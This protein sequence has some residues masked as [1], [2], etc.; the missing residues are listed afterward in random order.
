MKKAFLVLLTALLAFSFFSCGEKKAE[1]AEVEKPAVTVKNPDTFVYGTIGTVS[2]LDPAV[3]YDNAS[4]VNIN[5]MY[6]QLITYN[7]GELDL[8]PVL[9]EEVPT[10]ANGGISADGKTYRFKIKKGIKFHDGS[11]LT[12]EDVEYSIERTMVVDVDH[13]PQWMYFMVFLND[14]G[15][16]NDDGT[17]KYTYDDI[18]PTVEVDG[19][20]VVFNLY[21]PFEPFLGIIAGYW[22]AI[23]NKDFVAANGGW[24]G[25]GADMARVNNP[26]TGEETLYEVS[27]G[28]GPY[29]LDR[30][31]KGDELVITRFDDYHGKKPALAKGIY[32]VLDEWSTRKLMFLQGDIDYAYVEPNF[33]ADMDAEEG[34]TSAKDLPRLSLSGIMFNQDTNDVDNPL[35]GSGAVDGNGVPGDFFANLDARLA[36]TYAWDEETFIRDVNSGYAVDPVTPFPFGLAYKNENQERLPFDLAKSEEYFKK[37]Y[38]GKLWEN[39]FVMDLAYNEG[40]EIRG[41]GLRILAENVNSLNPKFKVTVRSVVWAEYLDLNKNKRMPLFFIGWAPDYPDPDNYA[42]PFMYSKGYFPAKGGYSNPEAD[43]LILKAKYSTDPKER[44]EAYFRLQEIYI[45]DAVGIVNVQ[46][47]YRQYYRTWINFDGGYYYQPVNDDFYNLLRYM[48][49]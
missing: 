5:Q 4:G 41:G 1:V 47:I 33:Y 10:M 39:G 21:Q 30:W 24:D 31:V 45:E 12:P 13:G 49:K 36:F 28:T 25:T 32:K 3:A 8:V 46:S 37:L 27:N 48:S 23:V 44:E 9:A 20:Y 22:G 11:V 2:T 6:D 35:I 40:N 19:D 18:D 17:F 14:S 16:R 43:E 15:S 34:I 38:D 29:K 42:D 7:R 26:P